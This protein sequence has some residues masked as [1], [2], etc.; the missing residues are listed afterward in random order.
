MEIVENYIHVVKLGLDIKAITHS[1]DRM[2]EFIKTQFNDKPKWAVAGSTYTTSL[3]NEYNLFLYPLPE[4]HKLYNEIKTYFHSVKDN[5]NEKY[6]IQCWL[7]YYQFGE[8]IDWHNHWPPEVK[9]WHGFYCVSGEGSYTS[10]K[11]PP[12]MKEVVI[13]TVTDQLVLSKSDGDFHRSSEWNGQTPRVTIAFDIVPQTFFN[14][15]FDI[16]NHWVPI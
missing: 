8:Y 15:P 12:D 10:Y 4:F 6:Y 1:C 11:L 16:I 7:N 13:P 14:A 5:P 3:F 2:Y 9:S